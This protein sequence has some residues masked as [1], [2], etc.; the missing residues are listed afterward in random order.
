MRFDRRAVTAALLLSTSPGVLAAQIV[1]PTAP[2]EAPVFE[3]QGEPVFVNRSD[4]FSY[5]ALDSYNEP[6]FVAAFVAA[7]L[8]PPVAERLPAEPM[9]YSAANMPDGIGVYGDVMRHVIGG[10]PEGWNFWAGRSYGWG[11]IDIGLMECLTRRAPVHIQ[12]RR[13]CTDAEPGQ[14]LE[15]SEDGMSL[16]VN[17]VEGIN[18]LTAIRSTR[19]YR[20]LLEP[21]RAGSERDAPDGRQPGNLWRGHHAEVTG[22]IRS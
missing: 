2:P 16:T 3:A 11:G 10:R 14:V 5:R 17:L 20:F 21:C 13:S 9:V 12:S 1:E 8:L 22:R 4:I 6:E 15:W 7:G 19:R 18:G